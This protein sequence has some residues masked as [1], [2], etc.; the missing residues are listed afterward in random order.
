[1]TDH[2]GVLGL[3][4]MLDD[5]VGNVIEKLKN[6]GLYDNTIFVFSSDNGGMASAQVG[7]YPYRG[8]K[9]SP[10]EGGT[11][12][13][14]F[15][16]SPLLPTTEDFSG[17]NHVT[18]WYPTFMRLGGEP[19]AYVD[20][21]KFDG[22]DQ[23]E[24]LFGGQV[25]KKARTQMVYNIRNEPFWN[26]FHHGQKT[27]GW[28]RDGDFKYGQIWVYDSVRFDILYDLKSDPTEKF[29]VAVDHPD[30]LKK[31]SDLFDDLAQSMVPADEPT[32]A[33]GACFMPPR[34]FLD[35]VGADAILKEGWCGYPDVDI[36]ERYT[37]TEGHGGEKKTIK[38]WPLYYD[39]CTSGPCS[40]KPI[41]EA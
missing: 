11:K 9:T 14:A 19:K 17:I 25:D 36:G 38:Q 6:T 32:C 34:K 41:V 29:N 5:L 13:P 18:D 28:I 30:Q 23:L 21:L 31:M 10:L 15:I 26:D 22:V 7:N 35:G 40:T 12:V 1:M 3:T 16:H 27:S 8:F 24:T 33:D 20:G 37:I 2:L 39:P 4:S